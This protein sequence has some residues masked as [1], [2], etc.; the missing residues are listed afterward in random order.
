[1]LFEQND[2]CFVKSIVFVSQAA[3]LQTAITKPNTSTKAQPQN[4]N[5]EGYLCVANPL[6]P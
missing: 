5:P 4:T 6:K 2:K 3:A 1:M